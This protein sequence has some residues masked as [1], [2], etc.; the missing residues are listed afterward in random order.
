MAL[1]QH[2]PGDSWIKDRFGTGLLGVFRHHGGAPV[3]PAA[4]SGDS[5]GADSGPEPVLNFSVSTYPQIFLDN[6]TSA[7]QRGLV[8]RGPDFYLPIEFNARLG[9]IRI[10]GEG[11]YSFGNHGVPQTWNRGIL[12]GH[13]FGEHTEAYLELY[14]IRDANLIPAGQGVGQFAT[15]YPKQRESTIG[16]GG[17]QAMNKDG[18]LNLLLM[19]GRSFQTVT[20]VNGQ[21]SWIAYVGFQV[22]LGPK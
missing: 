4:V 10:N 15:G 22:L 20:A 9:P 18:T 8:A 7:V 21:P 1:L 12:V 13:E 16:I 6:P 19:A 3:T 5:P 11:G 14:D 17:R 2:R